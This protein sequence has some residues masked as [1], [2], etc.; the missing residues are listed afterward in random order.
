VF[1]SRLPGFLAHSQGSEAVDC[2][3]DL[4]AARAREVARVVLVAVVGV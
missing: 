3:S 4:E 2:G 1:F